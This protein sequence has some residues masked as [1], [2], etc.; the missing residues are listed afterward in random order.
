[1]TEDVRTIES[2]LEDIFDIERGSTLS[3]LQ[4]PKTTEVVEY[5]GAGEDGDDDEDGEI[6]GQLSTI[7]DYAIESFEV[8]HQLT[9]TV[10]SKFAARNAEVAA[11][12][13][14]IALDSTESKAKIKLEKAKHRFTAGKASG[15]S[16]VNNNLI[17]ADRNEVM[18]ALAAAN[19]GIADRHVEKVINPDEKI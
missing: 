3:T 13:L 14:K 4:T 6:T 2:P 15:P 9:Q 10:D 12:Y 1:M 18:A 7:Y 19:Q 8:Q 11:Q 16:T 17:I 5:E